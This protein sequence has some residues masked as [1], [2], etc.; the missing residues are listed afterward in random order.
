[1]ASGVKGLGGVVGGLSWDAVPR[2]PSIGARSFRHTLVSVP[3]HA[4]VLPVQHFLQISNTGIMKHCTVHQ[5]L[6]EACA[7]E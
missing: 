2:I 5:G 6:V 7:S 3:A 1:M 4:C